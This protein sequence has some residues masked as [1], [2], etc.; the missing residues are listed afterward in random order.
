MEQEQWIRI[1]M[2][3]KVAADL[4]VL[5][6]QWLR[7]LPRKDYPLKSCQWEVPHKWC[8]APVIRHKR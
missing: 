8:R 4:K 2:F 1:D 7:L 3:G 6:E 5:S